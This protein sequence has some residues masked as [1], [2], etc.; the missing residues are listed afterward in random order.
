MLS[1][2]VVSEHDFSAMGEEALLD[3]ATFL[4]TGLA[5]YDPLIDAETKSAAGG[6]FDHGGELYASC[7]GCH[8]EDGRSLNFGSDDEPE[9]VGTLALDNPWEFLHKVRAGQP[10][11]GMPATMDRDWSMQDL[12]DLLAFAQSLPVDA[13]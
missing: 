8:G 2:E 13:P 9:Y 11:T 6:D 4:I 12:L 7:A 3:L 1:G 10:G 5:D